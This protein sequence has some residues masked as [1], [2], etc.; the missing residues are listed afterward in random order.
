MHDSP[1]I[2]S[3]AP[4]IGTP[5]D[6]RARECLF[7]TSEAFQALTKA[8]E[9]REQVA[10]SYENNEYKGTYLYGPFV[11]L[12]TESMWRPVVN[13]ARRKR[14]DYLEGKGMYLLSHVD[15]SK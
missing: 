1:D 3:S 2:L 5:N 7:I 14:A 9:L 6:D 4:Q 15:D 13:W 12:S 10:S 11:S 8:Q